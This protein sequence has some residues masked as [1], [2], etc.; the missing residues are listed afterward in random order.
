MSKPLPAKDMRDLL[1]T[2]FSNSP[3][4][5]T[6][7]IAM[8]GFSLVE[9][10]IVLVILGLLTG[11]ILAGQSLIRAAELRSVSTDLERYVTASYS[12]RDKYFAIPGDMTNA[13]AFWG[14]DNTNC[15][16]N[17]G[18]AATPGTCNGN[19]NAIID[20]SGAANATGESFQF[21]KQLALAGMIEGNYTGLSGSG[22]FRHAIANSN[23]PRLRLSNSAVSME[24]VGSL[25]G[26]PFR[27]NGNYG[28]AFYAGG[29]STTNPPEIPNLKPEE[30]W[31]IDTKMDD[32]R[33]ATGRMTSFRQSYYTTCT[34][35]NV[36]ST[37]AYALNFTGAACNIVVATGL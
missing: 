20:F 5:M 14:K 34:T 37:T 2:R 6:G 16:S 23:V 33:P 25:S 35:T 28:N 36:E 27:W 18:T 10:S 32:G 19:G 1:D 8:R 31:N 13:T 24:F 22:G 3:I 4:T 15:S 7:S 17:T 26:D 21:W 11:G 9:L 12:F 29:Q 30:M